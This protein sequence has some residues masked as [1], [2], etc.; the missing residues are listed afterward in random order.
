MSKS[1]CEPRNHESCI[2]SWVYC[3]ILYLMKDDRKMKCLDYW[4]NNI[5]K[6]IWPHCTD[7][8]QTTAMNLSVF[9]WRGRQFQKKHSL[10]SGTFCSGN[11]TTL[12]RKSVKVTSLGSIS[13]HFLSWTWKLLWQLKYHAHTSTHRLHSLAKL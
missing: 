9:G 4:Q 3:Y 5:K 11:E 6:Q 1:I 12:C 13:C 8:P 7:F 10:W 2:V